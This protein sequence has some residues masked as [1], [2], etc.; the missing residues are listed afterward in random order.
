VASDP[1]ESPRRRAEREAA[2]RAAAGSALHGRP[3][4]HRVRLER[5]SLERY[6]RA[7]GGPLLYMRRLRQIEEATRRH[8]QALAERRAEL[9]AT[10]SREDADAAWRAEAEAWD[11]AEINRLIEQHNRWYPVEAQL[12][13]D[14]RT[15]DYA[16]VGGQHYTRRPLDAAWIL[17]R[18]PAPVQTL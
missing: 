12:P 7:A 16:L 13:M 8:E 10:S 14:P 3:L 6:L 4:P 5:A 9:A 18:F 11:F 2:E 1:D 15:G 17:E